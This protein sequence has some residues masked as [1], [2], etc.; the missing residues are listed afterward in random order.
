MRSV[1]GLVL[2]L[3][4]LLLAG[5]LVALLIVPALATTNDY[6]VESGGKPQQQPSPFPTNI[7][8]T[9]THQDIG[10]EPAAT[11]TRQ[12]APTNTPVP[13]TA[14]PATAVP[15]TDVPTPKPTVAVFATPTIG[16]PVG[17]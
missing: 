4:G 13:P 6:G 12:S 2:T 1:S 7:A 8:I 14:V 16:H 3:I 9:V 15:A 17:G 10:G 5:G 11:V